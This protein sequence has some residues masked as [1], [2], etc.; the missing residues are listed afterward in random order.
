MLVFTAR[1]LGWYMHDRV[2]QL[3]EEL[4]L[5]R[6]QLEELTGA[7]PELG[8]LTALRHGMTHRLATM[9]SILVKK[10]PAVIP[11]SAFHSVIY[12]HLS[13]GGP[14]PKIFAVHINKLRGVLQRV[15][16]PGKIDTV[17]GSG[18]RANPALVEWVN[19]L[20]SKQIPK[21]K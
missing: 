7:S 14:E 13:D 18:Y 21:E 3:E 19:E 8:V 4:E 20:Y 11:R 10:A 15:K 6:Q 17:W 12:G 2:T 5:A 9:L 16:C 1:D